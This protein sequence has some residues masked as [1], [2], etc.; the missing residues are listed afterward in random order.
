MFGN[1]DEGL[2]GSVGDAYDNAAAETVM[3]LSKNEAIRNDPPFRVGPLGTIDDVE[4]GSAA[5]RGDS[6]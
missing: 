2:V 1:G 6:F 5:R 3:G 4:Q